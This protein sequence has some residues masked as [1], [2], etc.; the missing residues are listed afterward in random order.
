MSS[1]TSKA[2][3][4]YGGTLPIEDGHLILQPWRTP[5]ILLPA[6]QTYI[7]VMCG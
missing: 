5:L 6:T 3:D 7:A 1:S 4:Q 2:A